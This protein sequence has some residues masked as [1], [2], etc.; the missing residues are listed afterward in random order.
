MDRDEAI[1]LL[2]KFDSSLDT[3]DAHIEADNVLC[4]LLIHLGF[5]DVV[6]EYAK[7]YKWYA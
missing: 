6:D 7:I 2:R 5:K 1:R 4:D 3:E